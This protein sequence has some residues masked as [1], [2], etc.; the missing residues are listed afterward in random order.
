MIQYCVAFVTLTVREPHRTLMWK[1]NTDRKGGR[2]RKGRDVTEKN[3]EWQS[4]ERNEATKNIDG[5]MV[6]KNKLHKEEELMKMNE[7][8]NGKI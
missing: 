1:V 4:S 2:N 3:N 6:G 8:E 5:K 7:G